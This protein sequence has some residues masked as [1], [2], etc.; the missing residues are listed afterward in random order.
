VTTAAPARVQQ[1]YAAYGGAL[2]LM[3]ARDKEICLDGP[4][5][6]GKTLAIWWKIH[7]ALIKYPGA[8]ALALRKSHASLV[9]TALVIYRKEVLHPACGVRFFGGNSELPPMYIYPNGSE[10]L[11]GGL[12]R[13]GKV[14]S[15]AYDLVYINEATDLKI[16]EYELPFSRLRNGV[17][18]YQQILTDVNP[19]NPK[20]WFNR[21]MDTGLTRRILS[22]HTD[23]PRFYDQKTLELTEAGDAYINGILG[24]LTGVRR[25]RL[26][27]GKW[28]AAEGA[29]YEQDWDEAINVVQPFKIP[30]DWPRFWSIDFGYVHP[31]V[32]QFWAIDPDGQMILYKEVYHTGRTVKDHCAHIKRAMGWH[33]DKMGQAMLTPSGEPLPLAVI[34]DHDAGDRATFEQEMG[35]R[36]IGAKKDVSPGIQAVQL[37]MRPRGNGKPGLVIFSDALVER[38]MVRDM[39]EL[40]CCTK[41]E[42]ETYVWTDSLRKDEPLKELDDGCDAMR[43]FVAHRDLRPG[44]LELKYGQ[45]MF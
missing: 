21:R 26:K 30:R 36:T 44:A 13:P 1:S 45:Q 5:G 23:N 19:Q 22:R 35:L 8:R 31:F 6:T 37:R 20:H 16:E 39:K 38:D 10:M 2:E 42:I 33:E 27:D 7:L 17:M 40:P 28:M 41:D 29:I 18:P 4:A 25:L 12:D 34:A 3:S 32:C 24:N 43:Y 11:L 9:S 14:M 15:A